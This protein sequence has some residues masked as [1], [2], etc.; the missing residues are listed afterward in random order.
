ML[1]GIPF[2]G[3][4]SG[5]P[6]VVAAGLA[7]TTG[8]DSDQLVR[9]AIA[10]ITGLSAQ[11]RLIVL[12]RR[13]GLAPG[14]TMGDLAAEYAEAMRA[15]LDLPVDVVGTS[16]GGSIVQQVA[17]DHPEVVRRLVLLSTACRLGPVGRD[18]QGRTAGL[19]R[20]GRARP[21]MALVAGSIAP[22]GLR[23]AARGIGWAMAHRLLHDP[24]DV[25]DLA[26]TLEAE[27]G[28]DLATCRRP[29]AAKTLIVAGR[30][31]RFYSEDLFRETAE[32]IPGSDVRL[33]ARRGHI[34]VLTDPRARAIILGFLTADGSG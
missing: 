25:A 11:R 23:T 8:V 33:F 31:D 24:A 29:I 18:L 17:A 34:S 9:G 20:A 10:P 4:G 30:R 12:N 32:L 19:L 14:L 2:A 3:V 21:A 28:F 1:G 6:V 27:D 22:W 7:S 15:N 13:A 5:P 16:T 26:A